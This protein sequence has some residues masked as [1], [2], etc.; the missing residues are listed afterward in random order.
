MGGNVNKIIYRLEF[1]IGRCMSVAP[2]QAP[3]FGTL[4]PRKGRV[5]KIIARIPMYKESC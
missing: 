4:V 5:N 1:Q 2:L 3:K